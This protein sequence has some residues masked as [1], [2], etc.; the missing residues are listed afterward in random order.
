MNLV[1]GN[2]G[3][4]V[5]SNKAEVGIANVVVGKGGTPRFEKAMMNPVWRELNKYDLSTQDGVQDAGKAAVLAALKN[6]EVIDFFNR[7]LKD[8]LNSGKL[9]DVGGFFSNPDKMK[10]FVG[11]VVEIANQEQGT[12]L[13]AMDAE[14]V[15]GHMKELLEAVGGNDIDVNK[16][17]ASVSDLVTDVTTNAGSYY[18]QDKE[19]GKI[20]VNPWVARQLLVSTANLYKSSNGKIVSVDD[21]KFNEA[22]AA[23]AAK[24]LGKIKSYLPNNGMYTAAGLTL[25]I[26]VASAV[27]GGTAG[28]KQEAWTFALPWMAP[29]IGAAI[30]LLIDFVVHMRSVK[31]DAKAVM[32]PEVKAMAKQINNAK[33]WFEGT[34]LEQVV[35]GS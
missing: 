17:Y 8:T 21:L 9:G 18:S 32:D 3:N 33:P 30:G 34:A 27:T 5:K 16:S 14:K 10:A 28:T 15:M 35:I 7:G 24:L 2:K 1:V 11:T 4:V 6:P 20:T 31:K 29:F 26:I 23:V 19:T 12:N 25:G 22:N 13:Q